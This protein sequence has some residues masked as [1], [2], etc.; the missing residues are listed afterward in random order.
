ADL[1]LGRGLGGGAQPGGAAVEDEDDVEAVAL[2]TCGEL[3]GIRPVAAVA[4]RLDGVPGQGGAE[5]VQ[6]RA[7]ELGGLGVGG[8]GPVTEPDEAGRDL[9]G[10]VGGSRYGKSSQEKDDDLDMGDLRKKSRRIDDH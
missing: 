10:G 4:A 6:A 5:D 9:G 2:R 8:I 7:A 1:A 3:V